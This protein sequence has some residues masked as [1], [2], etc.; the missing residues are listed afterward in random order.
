MTR[1]IKPIVQTFPLAV[2]EDAELTRR[3]FLADQFRTATYAVPARRRLP[4]SRTERACGG[5]VRDD[6]VPNEIRRPVTRAEANLPHGYDPHAGGC[7]S[8]RRDDDAIARDCAAGAR[9]SP[10]P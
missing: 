8:R 7:T 6:G 5:S 2:P 10:P 4:C 3:I 1:Q 9:R